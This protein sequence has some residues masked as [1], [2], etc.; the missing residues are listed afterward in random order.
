MRSPSNVKELIEKTDQELIELIYQYWNAPEIFNTA[1]AE[2]VRRQTEAIKVFDQSS[3]ELIKKQ[4]QTI[5][6]FN[7]PDSYGSVGVGT[8]HLGTH[9]LCQK[10]AA[11]SARD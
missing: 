11:R 7:R 4:T 6:R 2:L 8:L 3:E 10:P 5:D 1:Q 9:Q